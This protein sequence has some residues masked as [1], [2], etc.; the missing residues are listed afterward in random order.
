MS[1]PVIM[2][3]P[4]VSAYGALCR[5]ELR[6]RSAVAYAVSA[7][8]SVLLA[9]LFSFRFDKFLHPLS[10]DFAWLVVC[11]V[12]VTTVS[13]ITRRRLV[14]GSQRLFA[15]PLLTVVFAVRRNTRL[16]LF[17]SVRVVAS[18]PAARMI[19]AHAVAGAVSV[20]SFVQFMGDGHVAALFKPVAMARRVSSTSPPVHFTLYQFDEGM[21]TVLSFGALF[22][23]TYAVI[24]LV[25]EH[26]VLSFPAAQQ[27]VYFGVKS[28]LPSTLT[29]A[30]RFGLGAVA[31][32]WL[33]KPLFAPAFARAAV[34]IFGAVTHLPSEVA[35]TP[36]PFSL[37]WSTRLFVSSAFC[38]ALFGAHAAVMEVVM[39]RAMNI[40]ARMQAPAAAL[41]AALTDPLPIVQWHAHLEL[42]N[43]VRFEPKRRLELFDNFDAEYAAE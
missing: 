16:S 11:V 30:V 43:A 15:F 26:L 20:W 14:S 32:F 5:A 34:V 19:A 21:L 2:P 4:A 40:S 22:G 25:R 23:A 39:T 1:Y 3:P 42:L 8:M 28:R 17:S 31:V 41:T 7:A 10:L 29:R 6:R 37:L 18:W 27:S 9:L 38:A 12:V 13:S 24:E 36:M 35:D 33:A